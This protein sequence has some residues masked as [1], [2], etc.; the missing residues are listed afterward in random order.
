ML[1]RGIGF[2]TIANA[3]YHP[4][5][6]QRTF[7]APHNE[8][9]H[10]LLDGGLVLLSATILALGF[11]LLKVG[12]RSGI[13]GPG[14]AVALGAS[15]AVYS[16]VDNVFSTPQLTVP[17]MLLC[18]SLLTAARVESFGAANERI[19]ACR[20]ERL[21]SPYDLAP[22]AR[23]HRVRARAVIPGGGGGPLC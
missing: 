20:R 12:S 22:P 16:Y 11:L 5:G 7:D 21:A 6:V 1:G 19:N 4:V 2:A 17:F 14:Y 8:Y 9:L 3:T 13:A 10:F 18:A 15:I 23:E